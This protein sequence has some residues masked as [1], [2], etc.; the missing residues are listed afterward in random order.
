M[1]SS[2]KFF[3]VKLHNFNFFGFLTSCPFYHNLMWQDWT[4]LWGCYWGQYCLESSN[5][6]IMKKVMLLV[7]HKTSFFCKK[8]GIFYGSHTFFLKVLRCRTV[9]FVNKSQRHLASRYGNFMCNHT[10]LHT[11]HLA[12]IARN[13]PENIQNLKWFQFFLTVEIHIF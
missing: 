9:K 2:K 8:W 11:A 7:Q 3:K 13:C 4:G 10:V 12:K 6:E 5:D 1:N